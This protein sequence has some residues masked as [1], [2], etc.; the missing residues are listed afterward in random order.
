MPEREYDA[1]ERIWRPHDVLL[2]RVLEEQVALSRS[3]VQSLDA[4]SRT[5]FYLSFAKGIDAVD[6][7]QA[8]LYGAGGVLAGLVY[9]ARPHRYREFSGNELRRATV[10]AGYLSASLVRVAAQDGGGPLGASIDLTRREREMAY[11]VAR[12]LSNPEICDTLQVARETVK[13]TLRRVYRKLE[14]NGRAHMVARL[15]ELGSF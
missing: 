7:L 10:L 5:D 12:G 11:L 1:Y 8:P 4:W 14:V 3:Q 9:F 6:C 2:A 13:Q 15:S